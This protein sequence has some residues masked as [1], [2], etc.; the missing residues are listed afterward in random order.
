MVFIFDLSSMTKPKIFFI[1]PYCYKMSCKF[2]IDVCSEILNASNKPI[3]TCFGTQSSLKKF[4][5]NAKMMWP[6]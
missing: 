6:L 1:N 5:T 4:T 2:L 3:V